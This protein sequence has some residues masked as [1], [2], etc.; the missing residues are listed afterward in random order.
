MRIVLIDDNADDRLLALRALKTEFPTAA[1]VE[2]ADA[3][4]LARA[5]SQ[6]VDLV[7]TDY[8]LRWTTGIDILDQAAKGLPGVPVIMFTNTGSEEIAAR[9]LRHGAADY[10]IKRRGEF[11]RLA[12][13]AKNVVSQAQLRR[14]VDLL[15]EEERAAR[16]EAERASRLREEFLATLS[17]ELRTPLQAIL[18]WVNLL[19]MGAVKSE[20][21]VQ[22]AYQ[23]LERNARAQAR[24]IDDLLDLSRIA[25]GKLVFDMKPL[26]IS[27]CIE[28]VLDEL[29]PVAAARCVTLAYIERSNEVVQADHN[30]LCQVVRNLLSNAIKFSDPEGRVQI[31]AR[32]AGSQVAVSVA[33]QGMG[34][35]SDF[36]P[37]IF[38]RFKQADSSTTRRQGGMGIGLSIAKYIIEGHGGHL[39]AHSA[40]LGQGATFNFTLPIL[41][42]VEAPRAADHAPLRP[43]KDVKVL[44]VEDDEDS[45]AM[46]SRAVQEAEGRVLSA[47]NARAALE[48]VKSERPDVLVSDI[49]MPSEDGYSLMRKIR[50]LES[51]ARSIPALALTAFAR[52]EDRQ[53]AL[54]AGFNAHVGK[55][56]DAETLIRCIGNLLERRPGAA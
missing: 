24:L 29:R 17:H 5:F 13:A 43:L 32:R 36:L 53:R 25:A 16:L 28:E 6:P 30:R 23:V 8:A 46:M 39:S 45:L 26:S 47:N 38:D 2:G 7:V 35:A 52:P 15:L 37:H 40:G 48:I 19:R 3:Q 10:V 41:Q 31:R 12:T 54:L 55:P 22:N 42:A 27:A 56:V 34:I 18:G 21:D 50:D 1:F 49:G 14:R 33:D 9:A 44:L 20:A 11:N 51:G 4:A